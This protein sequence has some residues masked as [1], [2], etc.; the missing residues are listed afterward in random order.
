MSLLSVLAL[1]SILAKIKWDDDDED[2]TW[3]QRQWFY[4]LKRLQLEGTA[5]FP[6][7]MLSSFMQILISPTAVISPIE[8]YVAVLN[9]LPNHHKILKSG[10]YKGHSRLYAACMRAIPVYPQVKSFISLAKNDSRFKIFESGM[11]ETTI[12]NILEGE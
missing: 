7:T 10:P 8:R 12:L 5:Y 2:T 3:I 11:T 1:L 6:T 4:Q 9:N